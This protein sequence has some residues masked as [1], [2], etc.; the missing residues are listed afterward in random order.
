MSAYALK[1]ILLIVLLLSSVS[2]YSTT[3]QQ[4]LLA[5]A[6]LSVASGGGAGSNGVVALDKQNVIYIDDTEMSGSGVSGSGVSGDVE[7]SGSGSDTEFSV[8]MEPFSTASICEKL[9]S[10]KEPFKNTLPGSRGKKGLICMTKGQFD[11]IKSLIEDIEGQ[12]NDAFYRWGYWKNTTLSSEKERKRI[13]GEYDQLYKRYLGLNTKL[14]ES[15][16]QADKNAELSSQCKAREQQCRRRLDNF[17]RKNDK[18]RKN[19]RPKSKNK[20]N[21]GR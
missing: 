19:Q 10:I 2:V 13:G 14:I 11:T 20:K 1:R 7:F 5:V 15:Q 18:A 12:T 3:F 9:A 4:F 8:G 16:K 21:N 6:A 17:H